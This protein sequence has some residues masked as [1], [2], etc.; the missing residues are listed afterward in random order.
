MSFA[1]PENKDNFEN[2]SR[3]TPC[4]RCFRLSENDDL[5]KYGSFCKSCYEVYCYDVPSYPQ[6]LNK[7]FGDPKG[8]AKR[9]LDKQKAGIDV[10]PIALKFAKEALKI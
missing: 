4:S 6:E 2:K 10:R 3:L 9:I 5:I 7:Y 1:K 8:W